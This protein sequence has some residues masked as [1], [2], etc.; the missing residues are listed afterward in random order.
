MPNL[1]FCQKQ[2]F[3]TFLQILC[4]EREVFIHLNTIQGTNCFNET[5][6]DGETN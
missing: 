3:I 1:K 2:Q 4:Y 6:K 5:A